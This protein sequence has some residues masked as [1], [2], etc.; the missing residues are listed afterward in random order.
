MSTLAVNRRDLLASAAV[1][2]SGAAWGVFWLPARS[3]ARMGVDSTWLALWLFVISLAVVIPMAA[4]SWRA[5]HRAGTSFLLTGLMT[6]P[7]FSLYTVSLVTTDVIH[8]LLLFYVSPAW[9][10]LLT[11]ATRGG[12]I[13]GRRILALALAFA[14]LVVVLG[15]THGVPLPHN[16]GDWMALIAG[17]LWAAG[18]TRSN[19]EHSL[20]VTAPVAAFTIGGL[21]AALALVSLPL[22]P[23]GEAPGPGVM[24]EALPWIALLSVAGFV[25]STY[26]LLWSTQVL[27][28]GRVGILLM[29][30]VVVGTVTAALFAGESFGWREAV[31]SLLIVGAGFVEVSGA[32]RRTV[33][34]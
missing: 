28:A 1:L 32:A 7:A 30:E 23:I 31:G 17:V 29:S 6:G 33:T 12:L 22:G 26:A 18:S 20:V 3:L 24:S 15:G 19:A 9:S 34:V 2:L 25:P 14:G 13:T 27:D 10:T 5:L 16:A 8:A 4:W 11:W 21:L